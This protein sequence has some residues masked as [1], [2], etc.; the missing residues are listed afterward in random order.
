MALTSSEIVE[1]IKVALRISHNQLDNDIQNNI[2]AAILDLGRVGVVVDSGDFL[3]LKAI[4]LFCKWQYDFGSKGEKYQK[5]YES[6]RNAL[7]LCGD[8]NVQ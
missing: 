7:S 4:E 5:A 6:M 3:I 1:R 8:Y 2:D